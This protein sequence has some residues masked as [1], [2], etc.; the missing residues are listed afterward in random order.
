VAKFRQYNIQLLP[1]DT[2]RTEEVGIAGYKSLFEL[3]KNQTSTSYKNKR[4]AEEAK[5]LINETFICPFVIHV[6][7]KFSYGSFVKFHKAETVTEFYTQE[8]LFEAPKGST[9]VSNSHNFRFI[10]DFENHR[11]AIEE[12]AGRLPSPQ[13]MQEALDHFLGKLASEAF[14]LH[15]LTLNLISDEKSLNEVLA[16]GN[17]YGAIRVKIVFPNSRRLTA[18]LAELKDL[19]AHNIEANVSPARGARMS[20]MP[21]YIR[22]LVQNAAEFGEATVTFYKR[23]QNKAAET[24]TRMVYSTTHHPKWLS[25]RQKKSEGE[26]EFVKRVWMNV[27]A[28]AERDGTE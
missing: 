27:K 3:F 25:L 2:K 5:A 24:F 4:M 21:K 13:V 19:S 8:R 6:E 12:G 11:F 26:P 14:P 20:G 9:P 18:T 22:E 1:L 28:V 17:E 16:K 15:V 10:F 7:D 23:T